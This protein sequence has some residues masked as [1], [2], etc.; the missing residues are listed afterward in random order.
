MTIDSVTLELQNLTPDPGNEAM[1][2]HA[3]WGLIT[4]WCQR[5]HNDTWN[6]YADN[7]LLEIARSVV[8]NR[9]HQIQGR[10]S[11]S[12]Q[13]AVLM[14][15]MTDYLGYWINQDE[16]PHQPNIAPYVWGKSTDLY[17]DQPCHLCGKKVA[18]VGA[19]RRMKVND[20]QDGALLRYQCITQDSRASILITWDNTEKPL[21]DPQLHEQARTMNIF[22]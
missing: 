4:E 6:D 8:E 21:T 19:I 11:I 5:T 22:E 2:R 18:M 1:V 13:E 9:P 20:K 16:K 17:L 10:W 7:V 14:C 3:L 15:A 12:R